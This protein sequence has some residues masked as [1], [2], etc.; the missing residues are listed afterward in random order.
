MVT[1]PSAPVTVP[2]VVT[3]KVQSSSLVSHLRLNPVI[4]F[5]MQGNRIPSLRDIVG[6]MMLLMSV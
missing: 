5:N 4:R 2:L 6:A 3:L 1:G